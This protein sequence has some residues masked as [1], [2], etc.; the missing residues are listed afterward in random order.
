MRQRNG[1]IRWETARWAFIRGVSLEQL[2]LGP[3]VV[4]F[5]RSRPRQVYVVVASRQLWPRAA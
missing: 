1:L 5:F 4:T 2:R 3:L